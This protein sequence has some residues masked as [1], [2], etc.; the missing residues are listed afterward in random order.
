M[1][2]TVDLAVS[3]FANG[4][5]GV[6]HDADGRVVFVAGALP[7]E[8]VRAR[9]VD[10]RSTYAKAQTAEVLDASPHRIPVACPAAAA[11]AG[12]CDLAYVTPEYAGGLRADAL[13]DVLARIGRFDPDRLAFPEVAELD[14]DPV[15]WRVRTRLAVDA[16]GA[17]GLRACRSSEVV[18]ARCSGPVAGLTDG[19]DD[20]P[21]TPGADLV[22]A[23][24]DDGR[25]QVVELA[26]IRTAAGRG[27][28]AAQR[29][30]ARRSAPRTET[31][32]DGDG[33]VSYRVGERTWTLPATGFWQA[34]RRA[35]EVYAQTIR[36][37]AAL[38]PD[39]ATST[40]LRVWDLYGGAGVLGAALLDGAAQGGP[41]VAGI[42]LV[43]TA[44]AA[45]ALAEDTLADE[46]VTTHRGAV[47][48]VVGNLPAPDLV[49]ADP[50]RSGT[51]AATVAAICAAGPAGVVHVGC[52]AAAF[53]RDLAA[54]VAA[55][56]RLVAWRAFDAFPR[57]SH[58][59]AIAVLR[60]P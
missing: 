18:T 59:E 51:G 30:R 1:T 8:R 47:E 11:G 40:G 52:D 44:P 27:R 13:G 35:P 38:V 4:G 14:D 20:L 41:A 56:Y 15:G 29:A 9:I 36:D 22:A 58:V 31:V 60:S 26:P 24:G 43:E 46:P 42:D 5:D 37:F 19:L 45:L 12:C 3:G 39:V 34:H 33:L 50:P 23:V 6:A 32:L 49:I 21:V 2:D 55:G 16:R 25:R 57:T 10:R 7:G 28:T 48:A 54:Y 53:A 17:V